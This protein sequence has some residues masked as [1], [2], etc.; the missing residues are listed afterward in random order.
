MDRSKL[1]SLQTTRI[2]PMI[3]YN[4][5]YG[6]YAA[7]YRG[8]Y[9]DRGQTDSYLFSA[10]GGIAYVGHT[11][12]FSRP[13]TDSFALVKVGQLKDILVYQNNQPVGRTDSSGKIFIPDLHAF[14]DNQ[15]RIQDQDVPMD[16]AIPQV[17]QYVS[18]PFR[19]GTFLK[20]ETM[21]IQAIT[22]TLGIRWGEKVEPAEFREIRLAIGAKEM[23]FPT[24]R[25]G[26]F[27][28]ENIE[29][30]RHRLTIPFRDTSCSL[31]ITIPKSEE[32]IIDLGGL[33]CEN[34]H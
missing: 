5:P 4:G 9:G 33:I 21:K 22:G 20:F 30:G 1:D 34:I 8:E 15:V 25:G 7:E 23:T 16:Y 3:Q 31:D 29:P 10:A 24:G 26:E 27:Y 12:G 2:N 6:I 11:L 17:V 19:S 32:T 13:V 28:L 14:V 18:P